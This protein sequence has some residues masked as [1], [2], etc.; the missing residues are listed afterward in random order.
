MKKIE[1]LDTPLTEAQM[2]ATG[3]CAKENTALV[4]TL[5]NRVSEL[6]AEV[7]ELQASIDEAHRWFN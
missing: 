2:L 7:A 4:V 6:E 1:Y 3:P 5:R